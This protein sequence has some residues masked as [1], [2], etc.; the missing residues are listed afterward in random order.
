MCSRFW[1]PIRRNRGKRE[2]QVKMCA[3]DRIHRRQKRLHLPRESVEST[4]NGRRKGR[5]APAGGLG[6]RMTGELKSE[7][8]KES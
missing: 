2:G 3:V 8:G 6:L 1:K 7:D 4:G 5:W